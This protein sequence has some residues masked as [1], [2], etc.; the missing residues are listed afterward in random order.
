[1]K[2]WYR[3]KPDVEYSTDINFFFKNQ[4]GVACRESK[5]YFYSLLENVTFKLK[6]NVFGDRTLS[7]GKIREI[8]VEIHS[9]ILEG[10][11]GVGELVD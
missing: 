6:S 9:E 11:Y 7:D 4:I 1:M 3:I 5:Y 2:A 8:C 10:K